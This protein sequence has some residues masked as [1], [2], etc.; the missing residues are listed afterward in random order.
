MATRKETATRKHHLEAWLRTWARTPEALAGAALGSNRE[1][2]ESHGLSTFSVFTVIQRLA[3]EGVLESRPGVGVFSG[4][5]SVSEGYFVVLTRGPGSARDRQLYEGFR[6]RLA[7]MGLSSLLVT[8]TDLRRWE[9]PEDAPRVL[10]LLGL[11]EP[12]PGTP[13]ALLDAPAVGFYGIGPSHWDTVAFDDETGGYQA[14]GH[15]VALG[16]RRVAYLGMHYPDEAIG[17]DWSRERCA[18]WA[19][20]LADAGLDASGLHIRNVL[21]PHTSDVAIG[22][23]AVSRVLS[24]EDCTAVITANSLVA[25]GFLEEFADLE[26]PFERWPAVVTF[27]DSDVPELLNISSI[28]LDYAALGRAAADQL[29]RPRQDR[30]KPEVRRVTPQVVPSLTSRLGW[31][32]TMYDGPHEAGCRWVHDLLEPLRTQT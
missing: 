22:R 27:Q 8:P 15:L 1:L 19:R 7:E 24:L 26:I 5:A 23:H 11:G 10:G 20:A 32:Q 21:Q 9:S 31:A 12:P 18:G 30:L 28:Y 14:A 4:A 3:A 29:L 16:H 2:A 6:G 13:E 25:A 17:L